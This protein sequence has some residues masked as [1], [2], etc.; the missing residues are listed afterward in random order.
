MANSYSKIF[1]GLCLALSG[2]SAQA[3]S[4]ALLES[5]SANA[6]VRSGVGLI[7]GWACEA[8]KIEISINNGPRLLAGYGTRRGDTVSVCGDRDNGFGLT[9]NWN[10][11]G[12]GLHNVRAF[13]DGVEF[14]NVNFTVTT[15]GEDFVRGLTK[16]YPIQN[17]P[18]AGQSAPVRWSEAHQNFVLARPTSIPA[19]KN[20]P[21]PNPR[22]FLESPTQGSYESGVGLIR[23]WACDA[24]RVEISIDGKPRL[25]T[26]HGTPRGDTT[27]VCGDRDNGFGLTFN[28][29]SLGDGV[30]NLQVFADGVEFASVNFAVT[31]LGADFLTG[32]DK[33][34]ALADFP[35]TGQI[36]TLRWSEPDQNFTLAQTTAAIPKL[37]LV[38]LVKD[39]R[40]AFNVKGT[41]INSTNTTGV[42][43]T[44]DA[45]GQPTQLQGIVWADTKTGQGA[46]IQLSADGLPATY[47]D[48]AGVKAQF[49]AVTSTTATVTFQDA[50]GKAVAAPVTVPIDGGVIQALQEMARRVFS[51]TQQE[52]DSAPAGRQLAE[53]EAAAGMAMPAAT[54]QQVFT[55]SQ[56]LGNA[57]WYG[58]LA[59]GETTCAVSKAAASAGIRNLIA[60]TACQSPL[61][62]ALRERFSARQAQAVIPEFGL[63]PTAQ[64]A[65]V[66][67]DD[68]AETTASCS[69]ATGSTACLVESA[70]LVQENERKTE[71]PVQPIPLASKI[72][73]TTAASPGGDINPPTQTVD[74]GITAQFTVTPNSGYRI[75][76]VSG[77]NGNLS[78]STYTTGPITAACTV[79]VSFVATAVPPTTTF[80][81]LV[82]NTAGSGAGTVS[83][84]G[85][86]EVGSTVNL[87]ATPNAGSTFTGWSP[88]PCAASFQMPAQDLTCTAT[89]DR[90][91]TVYTVTAI[92]GSG[93]N[94]YPPTQNVQAGDN[95]HVLIIPTAPRTT[96]GNVV[97]CGGQ[98]DEGNFSFN[99]APARRYTTA[100]INESCTV[101]ATFVSLPQ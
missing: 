58:S 97:G 73:V 33:K 67:I 71:P 32:L 77:C 3:Q 4:R 6:F 27:G 61:L 50:A 100:L 7:R 66:F 64:T 9:Y 88:V 101:N 72:T 62:T 60:P 40:E 12:D 31:T 57:Y 86:Y 76:G 59:T 92:A 53:A 99:G 87:T 36:T 1:V 26:A 74:T 49:S 44:K 16:A 11:I 28:W 19:P 51:R 24:K 89:F 98:L 80:A 82:L 21:A 45:Q 22:A 8:Q 52:A 23:G 65:L 83:G 54:S 42:R 55:L 68:Q 90:S 93:G 95:S 30:H 56:L 94:V 43:T 63:D 14:A 38:S 46:D 79:N 10:N 5:P 48:T 47:T 25:P 81:A 20:P 13:A 18:A 17:F 41:G 78:G 37:A 70:V 85:S 34:A 2:V 39:L 96:I 29:N 69:S 35:Q 15:L 91:A 75:N 84:G